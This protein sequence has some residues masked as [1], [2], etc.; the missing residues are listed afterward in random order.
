MLGQN[1]NKRGTKRK[2][3][4]R[5]LAT[6]HD[7]RQAHV[8]SVDPPGV[9]ETQDG[10]LRAEVLPAQLLD[11]VLIPQRRLGGLLGT[12]KASSELAFGKMAPVRCSKRTRGLSGL[13]LL[14]A[15]PGP[16]LGSV[17]TGGSEDCQG[18][19]RSGDRVS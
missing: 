18:P 16:G 4:T 8:A 5:P 15:L 7:L 11:F 3:A 6:W 2:R 12:G 13:L 1:A 14:L 10:G 19:Y 17:G 9:R